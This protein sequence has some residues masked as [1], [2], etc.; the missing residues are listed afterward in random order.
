MAKGAWAQGG[1]IPFRLGSGP[2]ETRRGRC[3]FV[4]GQTQLVTAD[5]RSRKE[6][7]ARS[8]AP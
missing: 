5:S 2:E 1:L 7:C 6:S 3:L 4:S 8:H